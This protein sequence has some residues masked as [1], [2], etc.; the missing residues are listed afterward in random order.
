LRNGK[1]KKKKILNHGWSEPFG[2]LLAQAAFARLPP[3]PTQHA[4]AARKSVMF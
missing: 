4:P 2:F 3:T 1:A